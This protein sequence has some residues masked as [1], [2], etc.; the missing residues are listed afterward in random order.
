MDKI[1]YL[2]LAIGHK[3]HQYKAWV[4]SLV[5]QVHESPDDYLKD[6]YP[7]RL[8]QLPSGYFFVQPKEGS[9]EVELLPIDKTKLGEPLFTF[10]EKIEIDSSWLPSIKDKLTSTVGILLVNAICLTDVFY[11]RIPYINSAITVEKIETMIAKKLKDTPKQGEQRD[12]SFFYVDEYCHFMDKLRYV[13]VFAPLCLWS[14]TKKNLVQPVGIKAFRDKLVKEYGDKLR[15]PAYL[16]EFEDKLRDFD[17]EYLKDDPTLGKFTSG[18]IQNIARKKLFLSSGAEMG[19]KVESKV[20]PVV[21]SLYDGWGYNPKDF[22][23]S[24]NGLRAGSF[25]RGSETIKGG[26]TAKAL[27]RSLGS[28]KIL[29]EDCGTKE[30]LTR[31]YRDD[32]IDKTVGR[33]MIVSG[34]TTPVTAELAKTFIDK[35]IS[36][37]SPL[38]CRSKGETFCKY[39]V[40]DQIAA[41][42]E[43][44]SLAITDVSNVILYAFMKLMHGKR[45]STAHYDFNVTLT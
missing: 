2:K 29:M 25:A 19:F 45:L 23:S 24:M 28:F 13:E 42:P 16:A 14:A 21:P 7:Y 17:K 27:L 30:G 4:F 43:G 34:K 35:E 44:L 39:C 1:Q 9:D 36:I 31:L 10:T 6:P 22:V 18:K 26:V 3:A 33:Y 38:Y 8:V 15:D 41:N 40:G 12:P 32:N 37:R 20:D 5:T 11:D